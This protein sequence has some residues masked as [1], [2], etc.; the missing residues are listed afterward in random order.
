MVFR[1][2]IILLGSKKQKKKP[3]IFSILPSIPK[4]VISLGKVTKPL[5]SPRATPFLAGGAAIALGGGALLAGKVFLGTALGAGIL[6]KSPRARKFIGSKL[7]DPT[8]AGRGI[9]EIIEDPSRLIPKDKGLKEKIIEAVKEKGLPVAAGVA[10]AGGA[11]LAVKKGRELIPKAKALLPTRK[12]APVAVLP[13]LP[14]SI[15]P[16]GVAKAETK[17]EP[18]MAQP[19]QKP[20]SIKNTFKP[21]VIISFRKSRKFINQKNVFR[22]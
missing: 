17:A 4:S 22:S 20:V 11:V 2:P 21:E 8:K 15:Q 13:S 7:R 5:L 19:T 16:I 12:A 9:G 14:P 1:P 18:V 3:K 6:E 10:L